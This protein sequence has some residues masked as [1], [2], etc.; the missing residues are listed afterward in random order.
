MDSADSDVAMLV[1]DTT[2]SS[3]SAAFCSDFLSLVRKGTVVGHGLGCRHDLW[4]VKWLIVGSSESRAILKASHRRLHSQTTNH[5]LHN[6]HCQHRSPSLRLVI[7]RTGKNSIFRCPG[8]SGISRSRGIP[9]GMLGM[10]QLSLALGRCCCLTVHAA[11]IAADHVY[12]KGHSQC[13][14]DQF[15]LSKYR[16]PPSSSRVS[17]LIYRDS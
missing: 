8:L 11:P 3:L 4:L 5:N 16:S 17:F 15:S 10:E 6:S 1:P 9:V 7:S 14:D 2:S 12:I 13:T